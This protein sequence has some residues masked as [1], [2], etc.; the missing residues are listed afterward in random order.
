M[1]IDWYEQN[2]DKHSAKSSGKI[3]IEV[4]TGV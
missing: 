1:N 3:D 2:I 4:T